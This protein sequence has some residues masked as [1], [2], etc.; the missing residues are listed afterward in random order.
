MGGVK[1]IWE[2][3]YL[4]LQFHYFISL[5]TAKTQKSEAFQLNISSGNIP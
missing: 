2:E 4:L 1:M 5:E 3:Q